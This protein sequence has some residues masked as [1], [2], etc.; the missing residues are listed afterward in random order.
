MPI[1]LEPIENGHV[2]LYTFTDPWQVDDLT[3]FYAKV[4]GYLDE[5][6]YAVHSMADLRASKGLV[7]QGMLRARSGLNLSHP[8][9]G[10]VV[11]VG[12]TGLAR[13]VAELLFTV[14]NFDRIKF[15]DN[16]D[17]ALQFLRLAISQKLE[18]TLSEKR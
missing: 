7:P 17:E 2:L 8:N 11:V 16:M 13:Q 6:T 18:S 4:N 3:V 14:A 12:V 5:T 1:T 9:N 15:F 10:Y